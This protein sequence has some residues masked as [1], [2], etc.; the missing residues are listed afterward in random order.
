[1][2]G[3]YPLNVYTWD[4]GYFSFSSVNGTES[5]TRCQQDGQ[6]VNKYFAKCFILF[7]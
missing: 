1:M 2:D 6:R 5:S 3:S 7:M 4:A